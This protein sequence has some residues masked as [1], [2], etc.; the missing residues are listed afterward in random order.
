[1]RGAAAYGIKGVNHEVPH[2][3]LMVMVVVVVMM[4]VVVMMITTAAN[5]YIEPSL[6][7]VLFR[8]PYTRFS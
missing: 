7:Q 3:Q 6:C 4:M 1:M 8:V 5:T 2:G